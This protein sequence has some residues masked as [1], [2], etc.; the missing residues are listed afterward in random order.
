M[1]K[2]GSTRESTTSRPS[3]MKKEDS[4]ING[5][6][7]DKNN[8]IKLT[9]DTLTEEDHKALETYRID[10]DELFYSLYEVTR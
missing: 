8:I 1:K 6:D 4:G 3:R 7:L 2:G 10:L 5:S 9:F